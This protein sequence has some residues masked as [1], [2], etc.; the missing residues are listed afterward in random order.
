MAAGSKPNWRGRCVR[1]ERGAGG[2]N[3]E[4]TG[5]RLVKL[6]P[7]GVAASSGLEEGD[8]IL[9]VADEKVSYPREVFAQI[10]DA[11]AL[12]REDVSMEVYSN[13]SF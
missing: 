9:S 7:D 13:A 2:P 10:A 1:R 3:D 6:Q 4:L 11:R 8:L 5:V 12:G